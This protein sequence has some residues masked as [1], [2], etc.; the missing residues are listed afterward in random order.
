MNATGEPNENNDPL[1]F[2]DFTGN[3]LLFDIVYEPSVTP[4]MKR[5]QDAGCKVCNGLK[6]LQYQ[7]EAQFSMFKDAYERS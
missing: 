2:Y 3:E 6:M 4:V 1:W 5:A 7:G